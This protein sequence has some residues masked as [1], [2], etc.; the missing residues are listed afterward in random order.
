[1]TKR[2][3]VALT[4]L[5]VGLG[6]GPPGDFFTR[7]PLVDIYKQEREARARQLITARAQRRAA[8]RRWQSA[9]WGYEPVFYF[10]PPAQGPTGWYS[11]GHYSARIPGYG[12]IESFTIPTSR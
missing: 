11:G 12:A 4:L 7:K 6:A 5:A 3:I 1:M 9:N 10:A 8:Y 2:P